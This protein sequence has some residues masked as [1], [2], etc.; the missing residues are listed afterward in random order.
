VAIHDEAIPEESGRNAYNVGRGNGRNFL[1]VVGLP[2]SGSTFL[3]VALAAHPAIA[4]VRETHLFQTYLGP[5]YD[6][7]RK[8]AQLFECADGISHLI[9]YDELR[10]Q[11]RAIALLVLGKISEKHPESRVVLE[12]TPG[13]LFLLPLIEACLPDAKILQIV[14]DPRGTIASMKAAGTN[15]WVRWAR[16]SISDLAELWRRGTEAGRDAKLRVGDRYRRIRYEDLF[17]SG[18]DQINAVNIG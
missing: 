8:E 9:S 16:V 11:L 10:Q 1:F 3:Q 6:T 14:R 15:E 17:V 12:K 18:R 2:R 5:I 13:H 7:F 4:T